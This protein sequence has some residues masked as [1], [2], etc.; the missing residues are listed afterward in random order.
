MTTKLEHI[1]YLRTECYRLKLKGA[2]ILLH[3]SDEELADIYNGAG[4]DSWSDLS[5]SIVTAFVSLFGPEVLI[6][7]VHFHESDGSEETFMSVTSDWMENTRTIFSDAYPFWT[8]RRLRADYNA[9]RAY[10]K[11]VMLAVNAAVAGSRAFDAWKRAAKN[12]A[13]HNLVDT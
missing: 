10:W 12:A 2:A 11:G 3:Y 1:F 6:H 5:R 9:E 8:W 7:D 13:R 4:P